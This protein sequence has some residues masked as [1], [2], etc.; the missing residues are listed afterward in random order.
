MTLYYELSEVERGMFGIFAT[1][2]IIAALVTLVS[3]CALH[4]GRR[5][6]FFAMVL[7]A[8]TMFLLQGIVDVNY[9]LNNMRSLS[10]CA[11]VIGNLPYGVVIFCMSFIAVAE[12]VFFYAL[13]HRKKTMLTSGAI[14]E[15]LDALPDGVCFFDTDGQ[16]LL[17]NIQMNRLCGEFFHTEILNV[18]SFLMQLK[19]RRIKVSGKIMHHYPTMV[20]SSD[21]GKVWEFRRNTLIIGSSL[22]YELV[23]Y[24]ITRQ[25]QLSREL[26][27]RNQKLGEINER[28][29][30]YSQEVE[31]ITAEQEILTAKMQ[32]HDN[33]GRSL[34]AFRA[35]LS[36][37][38]KERN[39]ESLLFLWKST[40]ALL[41]NEAVPAVHS[42]D[43]ELL[44]KAAKAVDVTIVRNGELPPNGKEREILIGAIHECLTNTVKHANGNQLFLSIRSS[45]TMIV[46]ELTNNGIP[47]IDEIQE[48][49]GLRNLRCTVEAAG[50][51][52]TVE[53]SPG[54][55]LR[56][57][58]LRGEERKWQK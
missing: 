23:A 39:K 37:T 5:Y 24:D 1:L 12:V 26:E 21:D 4:M 3:V 10:Y 35:Y 6:L 57:E 8:E 18:W 41:R 15:S 34:L 42:S 27:K 17:V 56:L 54:F 44:L 32:V 2:L 31:R 11:G 30:I 25:Y 20:V 38:E 47:P 55:V 52:M 9:Q 33:V 46:S 40:I 43:W 16:P 51:R 36:Q 7:T 45:D 49:G 19:D 14:K 53:S 28:L 29:R 50:G 58:L 13:W 48:T 22:I